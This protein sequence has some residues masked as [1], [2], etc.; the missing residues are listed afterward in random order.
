MKTFDFF[1]IISIEVFAF[2]SSIDKNLA[3]VLEKL[4]GEKSQHLENWCDLMVTNCN[5]SNLDVSIISADEDSEMGTF[6]LAAWKTLLIVMSKEQP[7]ALNPVICHKVVNSLIAAMRTQFASID[8][9]NMRIFISLSETCL[10][11]M[12]KWL[13]KVVTLKSFLK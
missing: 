6:L 13:T 11:L 2:K 5:N 8:E 3:Q 9:V 4:F 7:I 1:R 12:Q 10:I